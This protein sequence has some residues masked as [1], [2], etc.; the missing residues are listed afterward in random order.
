VEVSGIEV[1]VGVVA[2]IQGPAEERLHLH[3]DVRADAA[4]LGF[5]DPALAAQ[6]R[7]QGI[8]LAGGDASHVGLHHHGVEGLIHTP[9]GLKDRGQEAARAEFRDP[10]IDV[11]HLGGEDARPVAVAVTKPILTAFMAIGTEH[12]GDLQLDQLLQAMA[13]QFRDQFPGAA[14]IQ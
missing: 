6:S 9:P 8:D 3:V 4:H 5:R 14:A 10:Q 11:A 13:H 7:H 12:G 2:G 1:Q